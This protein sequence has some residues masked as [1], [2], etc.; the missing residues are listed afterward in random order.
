VILSELRRAATNPDEL[1]K[2]ISLTNPA[3]AAADKIIADLQR[4]ADEGDFN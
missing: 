3:D 2:P 4:K 1:P